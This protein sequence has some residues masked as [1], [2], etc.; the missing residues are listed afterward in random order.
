H[1][2]NMAINGVNGIGVMA[3]AAI[4][5]GAGGT[6]VFAP[7]DTPFGQLPRNL[8]LTLLVCQTNSSGACIT[9]ATPAASTTVTI[10]TN[11]TA[12]FTVFAAGQGTPIPYDPANN[13]VF[14]LAKQGGTPV[15]EASVAVKM[16]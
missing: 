8:P 9:P 11:Q 7:T 15:G 1:D 12:F 13:R 6:V 2:G 5:I 10:A 3:T 4:D 14:L 16:Q